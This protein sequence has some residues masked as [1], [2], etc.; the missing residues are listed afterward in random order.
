MKRFVGLLFA[1]SL[2]PA[3]ALADAVYTTNSANHDC[4]KE[5]NAV[6]NH[7]GGTYTFTGTCEKITVNGGENKVTIDGVKKLSITGSGN[8][9]NVNAAE[10]INVTGSDN[11]V[12][13]K[14]GIDSP[15]PKVGS[16]GQ[17]NKIN[18]VK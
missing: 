11:T 12:N 15:K 5:P 6:I 4:A 10:K 1:A 14:K 3:S 2:I 9:V 17:G 13:Y 7:G 18:Q 8:T 16:L